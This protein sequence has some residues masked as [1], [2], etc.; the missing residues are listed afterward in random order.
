MTSYSDKLSSSFLPLSALSVT[1]TCSSSEYVFLLKLQFT[2][3][4]EK[5]SYLFH[6]LLLLHLLPQTYRIIFRCPNIDIW[7]KHLKR[8]VSSED[9]SPP[10]LTVKMSRLDRSL[11]CL[12]LAINRPVALQEKQLHLVIQDSSYFLCKEKPQRSEA[13]IVIGG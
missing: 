11:T 12:G 13:V 6:L 7:F 1:L 10:A 8:M 3:S 9:L 5:K 4:K 2:V